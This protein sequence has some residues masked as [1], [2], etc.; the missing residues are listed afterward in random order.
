LHIDSIQRTIQ[1]SWPLRVLFSDNLFDPSNLTLARVL[2]S[3]DLRRTSKALL[4]LDQAL[5]AA[6][7]DLV[8]AI[9]AY[10]QAHESRLSLVRPPLVV[11][12]G[13]AVKNS[14]SYVADLHVEIDRFHIDRQSYVI[15]VG[16]GALLDMVGLAATTAHRGVRHVRVPTTTLSQC[17]SGVGVKNSVNAFGKKNFIGTFCPPFAVIND[18]EL[19][20]SLQPRDKRSGFVEAVK[21]SAIRDRRF[22][23]TL[24]GEAEALRDFE[25]GAM[26]RLIRRCAEL[27]IDHIVEGGD[28]FEAGSAR[29]L[30]FGH[31][32]AHK[33]EQISG[34]RLRHGEAVAI[35]IALDTVYANR[36]GYLSSAEADRVLNLLQGLG[37]ELYAPEMSLADDRSQPMMLGGL[38]EFREHLGGQLSITLL[39]GIG[40]PFEAH[41]MDTRC[42][43]QSVGELQQRYA[44]AQA[45]TEASV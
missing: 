32:S 36:K 17:D 22:F 1:V 24:E 7:P 5:A 40:T 28:P 41:E 37:L 12:G 25:P 6:Q 14:W 9:T 16:G 38:E 11:P 30:D 23:E 35:G 31:W 3:D 27:H 33:L 34:F 43:L 4:V 8:P 15:A 20:A 19:L 21:V 13:E 44:Q 2:A 45:R 26:R 42:I 10:F 29:P 18:F 39:R